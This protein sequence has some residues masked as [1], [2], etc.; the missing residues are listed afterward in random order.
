[1]PHIYGTSFVRGGGGG[2]IKSLAQI[3]SPLLARKSSGFARKFGHFKNSRMEGGGYTPLAPCPVRLCHPIFIVGSVKGTT[4]MY[5]QSVWLRTICTRS[6]PNSGFMTNRHLL[7]NWM[8]DNKHEKM[9][10]LAMQILFCNWGGG[11]GGGVR[12]LSRGS[13]GDCKKVSGTILPYLLWS[14]GVSDKSDISL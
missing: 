14:K 13:Y 7:S 9:N 4:D 11:G 10:F 6:V 5:R 2:L 12:W 8:A 1:M 3:F